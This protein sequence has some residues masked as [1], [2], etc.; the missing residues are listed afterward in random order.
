MAPKRK[1]DE[2][3]APPV[4]VSKSP[5]EFFANNKTI[6]GFDNVRLLFF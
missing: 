1:A 4:V 5:A 6:A 3:G 2:Q